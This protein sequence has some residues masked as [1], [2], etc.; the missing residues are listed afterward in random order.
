VPKPPV[1]ATIAPTPVVIE[2]PRTPTVV[3]N[4]P[5]AFD[6]RFIG[7]FGPLQDRIAAFSRNGEIVTARLGDRIG[8][9]FELRSIGAESVEVVSASGTQ[10][11]PLGR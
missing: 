8:E 6:Y 4:A 7:T 9:T 5:P 11:V 2:A 1:L 10:R 3:V